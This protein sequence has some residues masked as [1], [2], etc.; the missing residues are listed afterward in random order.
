LETEQ[1]I[2]N[3]SQGL[4]DDNVRSVLNELKKI[5]ENYFNAKDTVKKEALKEEYIKDLNAFDEEVWD[6]ELT[7]AHLKLDAR[8][9]KNWNPFEIK[10]TSEFFS[11]SWMFGI[12]DGFDIVIG[13]PPYIGHKGGSKELFRSMK[14]TERGRKFNNERMDIFYYFFHCSLDFSSKNGSVAFIT[15]NYFLNADSAKKLRTDIKLR[16]KITKLIN[17]NELKIFES[18]M[19]QHNIITLLNK[20]QNDIN[21]NIINV[22]SNGFAD[23]KTLKQI[24]LD[25]S[26]LAKY[27]SI[28]N[29]ELF[30]GELNYIR[31]SGTNNDD[32][33]NH[34]LYKISDN[35][36]LL[37]NYCNISQG[38]VSGLDKVS[39]KHI[40]RHKQ[41]NNNQGDG[42]YVINNEE[43]GKLDNLDLIKP[44]FKN[45]DITKYHL[46][47]SPK[48]YIIHLNTD[49]NLSKKT[50]LYEHLLKYEVLIKDR[51]FESGELSK[52]KKMGM[53]WAL[54]SSRKEFDFAK[55]KIVSPQ[56]S[57][58]NTF[59]Y[60]EKELL[61][62]ADVYFIQS[63]NPYMDLKYILGLLNSRLYYFWL[64][65]R[66]KRKGN[67]LELYQ[68]PLSE[69]PI[70]KLKET[71]QNLFI[72]I[73]DKIIEAKKNKDEVKA[74]K[75]ESEIDLMVYKLHNLTWAE[76]KIVD[77]AFEM[78]EVDY[79]K[80]D[81][82][83]E[84][85]EKEIAT[86]VEEPR[87]AKLKRGRRPMTEFNLEDLDFD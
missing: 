50:K 55:P 51:N 69:I 37:V 70:K 72:I 2:N 16:S 3:G 85:E 25:N 46:N 17:F 31:L 18:A 52:A 41:F 27:F 38:I 15:T 57:L 19:G 64:Y 24:L 12:I 10:S 42:V 78:S 84:V 74:N 35:N 21:A 54:S 75:L 20:S 61:A 22:T 73:V 32:S 80:K 86:M 33:I 36:D 67:M 59:A 47:E 82:G 6:N 13:N 81:F 26:E 60:T 40:R 63:N 53:W 1:T 58:E 68:T 66:G 29:S 11:P 83:F 14:L 39:P 44:W 65:H 34:I 49:S 30:E 9:I 62:S 76:V 56:R 4:N 8:K 28:K 71:S 23:E 7:S 45:S 87:P 77:P 5:R 43:R 79:D 48:S